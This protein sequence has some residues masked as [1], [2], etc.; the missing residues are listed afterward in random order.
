MRFPPNVPAQ[1]IS[2]QLT[3]SFT[4]GSNYWLQTAK[5]MKA[6]VHPTVKPWYSDSAVFEG[7]FEIELGYD[8]PDDYEG[9]GK[10]RTV[11]TEASVR[12]GLDVMRRDCPEPLRRGDERHRRR[13][14]GRR[15]LAVLLVRQSDLRLAPPHRACSLV[16]VSLARWGS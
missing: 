15:V 13:R 4:G 7:R 12:H 10:G 9:Q 2:D 5:L 14:H 6:D 11:I 1:K 8:H 3:A 16:A